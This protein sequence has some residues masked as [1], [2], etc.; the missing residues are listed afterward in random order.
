MAISLR[1]LE[2][3]AAVAQLGSVTKAA[4]QL[5]LSQ[6]AISMA[7][8]DLENHHDGELFIRRGRTLILNDRGK[9]LLPLAKGILK[10]ASDFAK[11]LES[12]AQEPT[13]ELNIG[14][15]TTIGNYLLP[16][17]VANFSKKYPKARIV[18]QVGNTEIISESLV[19]GQLDL[20]LIEGP[21]HIDSLRQTHWR[22]DQLVIIAAPDHPWR[23]ERKVTQRKLLTA[24][25]IMRETG[26]GTRE[27]FER[28]LGVSLKR[29]PAFVELGHT[30]AIKKAVEAGLGVS[31]LSRLAVQREIDLGVLI[32]I[33]TALDL[34]RSLTLLRPDS[35]Y[36][37]PLLKAGLGMLIAEKNVPQS[38]GSNLSHSA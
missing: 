22:D 34:S 7:L 38:S 13:G 24:E 17:L 33:P 20:A 23:T 4:K 30:E 37:S 36:Q 21:C 5:F 12:S 16:L 10:Q 2:V 14:A 15:S 6:S 1:K 27:V 28:A 35:E 3:F 25:W 9:L 11:H 26:S 32:A 29:L 8:A 19:Q 18:M 31:C